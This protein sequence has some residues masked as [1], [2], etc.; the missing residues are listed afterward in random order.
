MAFLVGG[1][2]LSPFAMAAP[3]L[4]SRLQQHVEDPGKIAPGINDSLNAHRA[5]IDTEQDRVVAHGGHAGIVAHVFAQ[6]IDQ[7]RLPIRIVVRIHVPIER[8]PR[9]GVGGHR[10][11]AQEPPRDRILVALL[12]VH[13]P[14]IGIVHVSGEAQL[15]RHGARRRVVVR[16]ISRPTHD[17]TQL[18]PNSVPAR[19][20]VTR[21]GESEKPSPG[22]TQTSAWR[23]RSG[24]RGETIA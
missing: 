8:R 24:A 1:R 5:P 10:V 6:L 16:L 21:R 7:R 19:A 13:E 12:H 22:G 15:G 4:D 23:K 9:I 11:H 14:G 18:V 20:V 17:P 3:D 2:K